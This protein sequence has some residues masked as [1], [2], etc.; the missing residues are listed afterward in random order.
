MIRLPASDAR[1][2]FSETLNRVA[3]G[4]ERIVLHRYG[5]ELVAMIP[6][7]DLRCLEELEDHRD[8]EEAR[9]ALIEI[10]NQGTIPWD[11]LKHDHTR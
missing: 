2:R 3:F 4:G 11:Q 9:A 6:I 8:G 10:E 1:D 7:E 5:K